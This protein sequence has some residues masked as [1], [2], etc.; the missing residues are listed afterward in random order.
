MRGSPTYIINVLIVTLLPGSDSLGIH[1]FWS[2]VNSHPYLNSGKPYLTLSNHYL[3]DAIKAWNKAPASIKLCK[4]IW[5]S[6]SE[7]KKFVQTL[8]V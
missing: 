6:K 1:I 7:I 3:N 8:P 2:A 4:S 5:S